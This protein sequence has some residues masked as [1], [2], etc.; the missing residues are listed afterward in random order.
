MQF[1][2]YF[3]ENLIPKIITTYIDLSYL[4]SIDNAD[5]TAQ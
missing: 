3:L 5:F 2:G 4:D 1:H